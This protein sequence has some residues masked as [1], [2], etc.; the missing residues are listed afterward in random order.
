M[1]VSAHAS[2]QSN[3][4]TTEKKRKTPETSSPGL[5]CGN[6]FTLLTLR[7]IF[8]GLISALILSICSQARS[9]SGVPFW[10]SSTPLRC[11]S[12]LTTSIF[13]RA[14]IS[15]DGPPGVLAGNPPSVYN[16][17][18]VNTYPPASLRH[19]PKASAR[20]AFGPRAS[21]RG[22]C[23]KGARAEASP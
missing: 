17:P 9:A 19:A 15:L 21:P 7:T 22:L 8:P 1:P 18:P 4:I 2:W 3:R 12:W 6:G 23:P 14:L 11:A 5:L 20:R 13:I 16:R 10:A